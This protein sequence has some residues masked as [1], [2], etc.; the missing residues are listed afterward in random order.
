[1]PRRRYHKGP[2]LRSVWDLVL[3]TELGSITYTD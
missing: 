3:R 2:G 1:M